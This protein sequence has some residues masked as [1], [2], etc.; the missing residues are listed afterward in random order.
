MFGVLYWS[1][2]L[3]HV[4]G[5]K[6]QICEFFV[7]WPREKLHWMT[8]SLRANGEPAVSHSKEGHIKGQ[9]EKETD[10]EKEKEK[11]GRGVYAEIR[12]LPRSQ[13]TVR[14]RGP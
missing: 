14:C 12:P 7:S 4:N 8:E 1:Y 9:N 2:R 13:N 11:R 3:E 5:S 6:C 10:R